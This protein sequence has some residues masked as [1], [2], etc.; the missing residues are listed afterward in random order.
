MFCT[1]CGKEISASDAFCNSCG[2]SLQASSPTNYR[3][4]NKPNG[5][6]LNKIVIVIFSIAILAAIVRV[7]TVSN[8]GSGTSPQNSTTP[9]D[10]VGRTIPSSVTN[11][12]ELLIYRCGTP[13]TDESAENDVP[14]PPIPPRMLT[15]K[16][17]HLRF[18][19]IPSDS[20]IG[21]P[22]P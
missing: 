16:K 14:R 2:H 17:A 8:E 5:W 20:K 4:V 13:D 9:T 3:V 12:A 11:D 1:A 19:Y 21:D 7:A 15:Y 22:P 18:A 10:S 6:S